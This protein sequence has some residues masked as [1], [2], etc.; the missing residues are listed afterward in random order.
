MDWLY[1]FRKTCVLLFLRELPIEEDFLVG[2]FHRCCPSPGAP[3]TESLDWQARI[4]DIQL[5]RV[6]QKRRRGEYQR[7]GAKSGPDS[8]VWPKWE[9]G[10]RRHSSGL[11]N[12][13]H[14]WIA[15]TTYCQR[16]GRP[17][18]LFDRPSKACFLAGKVKD[19]ELLPPRIPAD[20]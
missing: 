6:A 20:L 2:L 18:T 13:G 19:R 16:E 7:S 4:S 14:R 15:G 11:T 9:P 12:S 1:L 17:Q 3:Q 8:A 10:L 5:F